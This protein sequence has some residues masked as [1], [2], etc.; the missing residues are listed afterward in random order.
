VRRPSTPFRPIHLL[1]GWLSRSVTHVEPIRG[2]STALPSYVA[3]GHWAPRRVTL[4][5]RLGLL[6]AEL[7]AELSR[8]QW[9]IAQSRH[10]WLKAFL[11]ADLLRQV[12]AYETSAAFTER[13]RAALALAEAV[14]RHTDLDPAAQ[15][16]ALERAR[17]HFAE[18]EVACLA[19]AGAG[20]HFFDPVTGA[21]G[22]DALAAS[23]PSN[24]AGAT[25][26]HAID[27][28]ITIRGLY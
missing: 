6:V 16:P 21:I 1:F 23:L 28:G 15:E 20:E 14:A 2:G 22:R 19:A 4:D 7:S 17:R 12:R 11:P 8:C 25:P 10:Q 27:R 13:E 3:L 5:T 18:A 26:W 24:E 9:C